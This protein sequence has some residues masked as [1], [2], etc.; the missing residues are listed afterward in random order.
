MK[1]LEYVGPKPL[2]SHR[3]I[4]FDK[5][6]DDK[7]N[8]LPVLIE[9]IKALDHDYLKTNNTPLKPTQKSLATQNSCKIYNTTALI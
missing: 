7:F 8:V 1:K 6:Q 5:N 9:L 2:I 4:D 3:G